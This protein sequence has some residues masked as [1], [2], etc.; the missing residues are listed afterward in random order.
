M[1]I[2]Y[3]IFGVFALFCISIVLTIIYE[4]EKKDGKTQEAS[5]T[6][7]VQAYLIS[8]SVM[9]SLSVIALAALLFMHGIQGIKSNV[10]IK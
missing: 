2:S 6:K 5:K 3:Q 8:M 10:G 9:W 7:H 4:I 1:N